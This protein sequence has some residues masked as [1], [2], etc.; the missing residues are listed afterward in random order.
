MFESVALT[1][2][3]SKSIFQI[4]LSFNIGFRYFIVQSMF[5]IFQCSIYVSDIPM[6]CLCFRYF[7]VQSMFENIHVQTLIQKFAVFI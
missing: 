1:V 6:F 3:C 7:H 4:I 5:Q 2:P